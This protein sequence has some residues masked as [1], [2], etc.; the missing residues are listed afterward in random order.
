MLCREKA[1]RPGCN[2]SVTV[3]AQYVNVHM[4]FITVPPRLMAFGF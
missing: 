1:E 3:A 4:W 2:R